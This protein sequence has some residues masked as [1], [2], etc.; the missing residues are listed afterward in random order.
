MNNSKDTKRRKADGLLI[1][2]SFDVASVSPEV[3]QNLI[4]DYQVRQTE[5]ELQNEDLKNSQ[6]E[7][8][9]SHD[10]Y[11]QLYNSSPVAYLTLTKAGNIEKANPAAEVLLA[12][13]NAAIS[14]KKFSQFIHSADLDDYEAFIQSLL[15][16]KSDQVAT[17][18][19]NRVNNKTADFNCQGLSDLDCLPSACVF[20]DGLVS[21]ECRG[22]ATINDSGATQVSLAL[23]DISELRRAY[24]T[25]ACLNEKLKDKLQ[26]QAQALSKANQRLFKKVEQVNLYKQQIFERERKLDLIF[27]STVEAIITFDIFGNILSANNAVET[28]FGYRAKEL[29]NRPIIKIIPSLES[30]TKS[31]DSDKIGSFGNRLLKKIGNIIESFGIHK[32][33][34]KVYLDVSLTQ[35]FIAEAHYFTCIVRDISE[36]KLQEQRD[37]EHLDA[38]A[39]VVRLGLMGEMASGI[40]HEVNQ[41]LTAIACYSQACLNLIQQKNYDQSQL[42][43]ILHKT[44]HQALKAG[45]IIHRLREFVKSKT[46][47][48]S[49]AFINDLIQEA[50]G[51]C[52]S[53]LKQNSIQLHMQLTTNLPSLVID[54]I[55]IEQVILNLI[56]NSIDSLSNLALT[57]PRKLS[58]QT[59]LDSENTIVVRIKDN[60]PGIEESE[61]QKIL[62]PF[63][64]TKSDGMGMGLSICRS[65]IEAHEGTLH[66][67]SLP[68]KGTT[69]YFSLPIE[70]EVS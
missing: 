27:D 47:H 48:A 8:M 32:D 61:Q 12:S 30:K 36:R 14:H 56:K 5:L 44:N 59:S 13:D 54:S 70:R 45:R 11:A 15:A 57:I 55:Q 3:M 16:G 40:A 10:C 37:K 38:L 6:R 41:P 64:T 22:A 63:Y 35:Y 19:L 60:G 17:I 2:S 67:N 39:H 9:L 51:L 25:I 43:D 42:S 20:N 7:L 31:I 66:F 33:G 18:H 24:Q 4:Y 65:I 50:V 29:I 69:F 21:I 53:H 52:E 26:K 49:T 28:I 46:L 58:I 1:K 34:S 23:L 68:Y 62:T